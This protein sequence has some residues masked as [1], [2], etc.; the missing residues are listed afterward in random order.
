MLILPNAISTVFLGITPGLAT[1]VV[2][3]ALS[4]SAFTMIPPTIV[5]VLA[6]LAAAAGLIPIMSLLSE[7]LLS[8]RSRLKKTEPPYSVCCILSTLRRAVRAS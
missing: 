6:G 4:K 8:T 3:K 5:T 2:E 7:P 1:T